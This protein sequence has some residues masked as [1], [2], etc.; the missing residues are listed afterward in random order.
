MRT[1]NLLPILALFLAWNGLVFADEAVLNNP[2]AFLDTAKTIINKLDPSYETIWD[3]GSG[4][5]S[6]GISGSLYNF[7]SN[8]IPIL[9]AR[10]GWGT[11]ASLYG[12]IGLDVPGLCKRYIPES[13]KGVATTGP[14]DIVWAVAGKYAR[15]SAVGGYAWSDN[16]PVYGMTF[17]AAANF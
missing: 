12:G 15:V 5:F 11:N 2:P 9:S 7:T 6:Q 4:T 10:A 8:E 17:G 3:F 16:E 13:V 14:L 1:T